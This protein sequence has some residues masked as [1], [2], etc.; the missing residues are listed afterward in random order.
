M[1]ILIPKFRSGK[2]DVPKYPFRFDHN[3]PFMADCMHAFYF[4]EGAGDKSF[5]LIN[6]ERATFVGP[7]DPT[8]IKNGIQIPVNTTTT[9][10]LS[11][12]V[13]AGLEEFT[14]VFMGM[15]G[16]SDLASM[17]G[18]WQTV[19]NRHLLQRI[20]GNNYQG[21]V[22]DSSAS[23]IGGTFGVLLTAL[24][25]THIYT[26]RHSLVSGVLDG[27]L[28]GEKLDNSFAV[29]LP[30]SSSAAPTLIG[31][32][33][34][35]FSARPWGGPVN[36][37]LIY[38]TALTDDLIGEIADDI[39]APF[40]STKQF[41]FAQVSAVP[42]DVVGIYLLDEAVVRIPV[43]PDD[44]SGTVVMDEAI[45]ESL[46]LLTPDDVTGTVIIDEAVVEQ[47][48]TPD[49]VVGVAVL[50]EAVVT[51]DVQP[52]NVNVFCLIDEAIICPDIQ[53]DNVMGQANI[54]L[55]FVFGEIIIVPDNVEGAVMLDT[56]SVH[57]ESIGVITQPSI[58]IH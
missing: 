52:D 1:T 9:T 28:D 21:F 19:A 39:Y 5:D 20:N 35:V 44:V 30:V 45:V 37:G 18:K 53:P 24:T 47:N 15:A 41:F 58:I 12:N 36:V 33:V 13:F 49:D 50:S 31:G 56:A 29:S 46:A 7:P 42:A 38:K 26:L 25:Q 11:K 48:L 43:L 27:F 51:V 6:S 10:T 16:R 32:D 17:I 3:H 23:Q 4:L 55:G 2:T 14:T 34:P 8:W 54:D 22:W 40:Y 57:L